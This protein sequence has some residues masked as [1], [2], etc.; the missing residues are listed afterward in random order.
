MSRKRMIFWG[1]FLFF[2]FAGIILHYQKIAFLKAFYSSEGQ[3]KTA[4]FDKEFQKIDAIPEDVREY[5]SDDRNLEFKLT[6]R[7]VTAKTRNEQTDRQGKRKDDFIPE[8][9]GKYKTDFP[10][11]V[12]SRIDEPKE[13]N[14]RSFDELNK[15]PGMP[16]SV[17]FRTTAR[18]WAHVSIL[19]RREGFDTESLLTAYAPIYIAL[20]SQNNYQTGMLQLYRLLCS[21]YVSASINELLQWAEK[22]QK[23]SAKYSKL[24]AKDLL[25]LVANEPPVSES[26]KLQLLIFE[27]YVK[28]LAKRCNISAILALLSSEWKSK[29]KIYTEFM[30]SIDNKKYYEYKNELQKYFKVFYDDINDPSRSKKGIAAILYTTFFPIIDIGNELVLMIPDFNSFIASVE[31]KLAKMEFTAIALAY[32][33]FHAENGRVPASMEELEKWFGQSLPI[34]RITG[35]PYKFFE[36]NGYTLYHDKFYYEFGIP[37]NN[38]SYG[39]LY[40]K[41]SEQ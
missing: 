21:N 12:L 11:Y 32:N 37:S 15:L 26:M 20:D 24:L 4:F 8:N 16:K 25:L 18:M 6:D 14:K 41:F 31:M 29:S 40:F 30:E 38:R 1:I 17:I 39:E 35:K 3:I 28:S 7:T 23:N 13:Y 36:V 19:L 27:R 33:S 10:K 5:Y 2:F 34:D 9:Y 22:P